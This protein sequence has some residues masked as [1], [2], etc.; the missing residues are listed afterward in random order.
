MARP[1]G[2][3]LA[4]NPTAISR[5][6]GGWF[7]KIWTQ[8]AGSVGGNP[9]ASEKICLSRA[10]PF[11]VWIADSEPTLEGFALD[12]GQPS[13]RSRAFTIWAKADP[14]YC[15]NSLTPTEAQDSGVEHVI[16][17]LPE[18][19]FEDE[20]AEELDGG[21]IFSP[22]HSFQE[23]GGN[24]PEVDGFVALPAHGFTIWTTPDRLDSLPVQVKDDVGI[25]FLEVQRNR[26]FTVWLDARCEPDSM[27]ETR[28]SDS[29]GNLIDEDLGEDLPGGVLSESSSR[30]RVRNLLVLAALFLFLIGA[31]FVISDKNK[32]VSDL[33]GA[34]QEQGEKIN[35][36]KHDKKELKTLLLAEHQK[37]AELAKD[38]GGLKSDFTAAQEQSAK[39]SADLQE[40]GDQLSASLD[41][42]RA[43]LDNSKKEVIK[44]KAVREQLES[45]QKM[46]LTQLKEE[47]MKLASMSKDLEETKQDLVEMG[48]M[49]S[50]M[51]KQLATV[52]Q[53][54]QAAQEK[55]GLERLRSEQSEKKNDQ[56]AAE[57]VQLKAEIEKMLK[58]SQPDQSSPS[59][60]L[61]SPNPP[62]EP[63]KEKSEEK[64]D[65]GPL[66]V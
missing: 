64:P 50:L 24:D 3:E 1:V 28:S 60:Q 61:E 5:P 9:I 36:L 6:K 52:S 34:V 58:S 47:Q 21:E 51:Q 13:V 53:S 32:E 8:R 7:A 29:E 54:L 17:P 10:N 43:M 49:E 26:A 35:D 12:A 59:D 16:E 11:T 39:V 44:E 55:M 65:K 46:L 63:K 20:N 37:A 23:T 14:D 4:R 48:K 22:K 19:V 40:R 66:N 30:G 33:I 38:L 25:S 15:A 31:M 42:A 2:E 57:V 41:Q 56:L 45:N 62:K 18:G 27:R